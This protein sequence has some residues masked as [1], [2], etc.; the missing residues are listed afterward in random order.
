M[1][2]WWLWHTSL[3]SANISGWFQ[4]WICY[5]AQCPGQVTGRSDGELLP[6]WNNKVFISGNYHYTYHHTIPVHHA[7]TKPHD[8]MTGLS[9]IIFWFAVI[10]FWKSRESG[11]VKLHIQHRGPFIQTRGPLKEQTLG[12][13]GIK[14]Q[15]DYDHQYFI[16]TVQHQLWGNCHIIL[17]PCQ[18]GVVVTLQNVAPESDFS[19]FC[20]SLVAFCPWHLAVPQLC[21]SVPKRQ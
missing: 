2:K 14:L 13:Q 20:S 1:W 18:N 7:I 5:T 4:V 19:T 21:A 9:S 10:W 15:F 8:C 16:W 17:N 12:Q 6:Q 11:C 3:S